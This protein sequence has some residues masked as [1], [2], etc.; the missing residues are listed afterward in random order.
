MTSRTDG[1]GP[2]LTA[3][4]GGPGRPTAPAGG[5]LP[6]CV[7]GGESLPGG[8]IGARPDRGD[9]DSGD[10]AVIAGRRPRGRRPAPPGWRRAG[11][12]VA[13][14]GLGAGCATLGTVV[15]ALHGAHAGPAASVPGR[16]AI[17]VLAR[18]ASGDLPEVVTVVALG[19]STEEL[20]TAW[21]IDARG[22]FV[23]NDHVVRSGTTIHV[24]AQ[25]Q[26]EYTAV[27]IHA[28]P[29][30]DLA[31]LHVF[32]LNEAPFPLSRSAAALGEP[33]VVLAAEGATARPPVTES[34]VVGLDEAATVVEANHRGNRDYSGLI[35]IPSRIYAGNS[36]G[37]VLTES[38][39]VVGILTLAARTGRGAFAIPIATLRRDIGRWSDWRGVAG[40]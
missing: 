34:R 32:G 25:G 31:I 15:W 19:R 7:P 38:G 8:G 10:P 22:D 14:V 4:G 35:R 37:P 5:P 39:R 6:W 20:G 29:R 40:G 27:V 24:L 12:A 1:K 33:V 2:D 26:R 18:V 17:R 23:T 11:M 28:D 21:P 9:P 16:A 3:G 30:R 13:L 36:G